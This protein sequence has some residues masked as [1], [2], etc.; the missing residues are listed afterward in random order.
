MMMLLK[1][2]FSSF[3]YETM[4]AQTEIRV[5]NFANRF[6]IKHNLCD[7]AVVNDKNIK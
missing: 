2:E 3:T 6:K 7:N 5:Y 1:S 4:I